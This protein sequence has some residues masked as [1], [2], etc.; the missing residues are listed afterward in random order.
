MPS[1]LLVI[2]GL[3]ELDAAGPVSSLC[4]C[5]SVAVRPVS[6]AIGV[7]VNAVVKLCTRRRVVFRNSV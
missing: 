6:D 1:W 5:A 3:L 4:V 7:A 2:V